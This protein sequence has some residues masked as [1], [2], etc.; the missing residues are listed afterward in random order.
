MWNGDLVRTLRQRG[1]G[2]QPA[3]SAVPS[4]ESALT[5]VERH[6]FMVVEQ[7]LGDGTI[8]AYRQ[9]RARATRRRGRLTGRR[10]P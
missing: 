2:A 9:S 6:G 3:R 5:M 1:R 7:S 8:L 4:V 10:S